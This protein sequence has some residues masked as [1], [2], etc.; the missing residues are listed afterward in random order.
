[1]I[2]IIFVSLTRT[3]TNKLTIFSFRGTRAIAKYI[4]KSRKIL[5]YR[6]A[7]RGAKIM[8]LYNFGE[9]EILEVAHTFVK[10]YIISLSLSLTL[11]LSLSLLPSPSQSLHHHGIPHHPIN[12]PSYLGPG[13]DEYQLVGKEFDLLFEDDV[14]DGEGDEGE[15]VDDGPEGAEAV[16]SAR[17]VLTTLAAD[18]ATTHATTT[19]TSPITTTTNTT[20]ALPL[21]ATVHRSSTSPV[22]TFQRSTTR[23]RGMVEN[24]AFNNTVIVFVVVI[25]S[26]IVVAVV[27][28]VG[29]GRGVRGVALT[30]RQSEDGRGDGDEET[31][32]H[33]HHARQLTR[34][35]LHHAGG[36]GGGG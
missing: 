9:F 35:H 34:G 20:I 1:M 2:N 24:D 25:S 31:H 6:N 28:G 26:P 13:I 7:E 21:G 32:H 22:V 10:L 19:T 3:A 14:V 36:G 8:G 5:R 16:T 23:R 18:A 33:H 11:S 15:R 4:M 30:L 29:C 27:V 17:P 12:P